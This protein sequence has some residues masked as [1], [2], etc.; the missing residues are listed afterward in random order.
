MSKQLV[1]MI[2]AVAYEKSM[3]VEVVRA[4]MEAAISA[5]ARREQKNPLATYRSS[6]ANDGT[7]TVWRAWTVVDEV[8]DP[9]KEILVSDVSK[10]EIINGEATMPVATPKWTRQ[11]LQ[12][13]KQV[14][15]Q[16]LK[17]GFRNTVADVW[18]DRIGDI[19]NG[20]VKRVDK[21]KIIVDL[22]EP[23]EGTISGK[24][25]I[26]GEIFKVGQRCKAIVKSVSPSGN[27][28]VIA[29][30]RSSEDFLRELI[31]IEVPEVL[32]NQVIIRGIAREPGNRAKIAVQ[33]GTNLK[34]N[35]TSVCIGMRGVRSQNIS[36]EIRGERLEF[37]EWDENFAQYVVS[38]L[39]PAEV[40]KIAVYEDKNKVLIG[41]DKENLP[42]AI[43]AK[44]QN[45]RLASKLIGWEIEMLDM[46]Q[47]QQ[48]QNEEDMEAIGNLME[49]LEVDEELASFLVE[50]GFLNVET[51]ALTSKDEMLEIFEFNDELVEELMERANNIFVQMKLEE[52]LSKPITELSQLDNISEDDLSVLNKQGINSLEHLAE[53]GLMDVIWNEDRD[54]ELEHWIMQA[55]KAIGMI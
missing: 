46:E 32:M 30:S 45:V 9:E 5:L 20:I 48:K 21:N 29:L 7:V 25:R 3:P 47:L 54:D 41:V 17:Q 42:R 49:Q 26:P 31:T 27:G 40:K 43:G 44:G 53:L 36:N 23:M 52:E 39:A 14:L 2:E 10:Y 1:D 28:P 37:I 38:A 50:E 15:A 22:G 19:V 13:V 34:N 35:P 24:D 12:V 55:R 8:N 6:I 4:S 11:G 16:R 18:E 51:I 33:A